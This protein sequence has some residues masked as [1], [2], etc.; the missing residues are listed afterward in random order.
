[1]TKRY[2]L[3]PNRIVRVD[4]DADY[5]RNTFIQYRTRGGSIVPL[6]VGDEAIQGEEENMKKE[7]K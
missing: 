3:N 1:M 6:K 2:Y 4:N 7:G 5:H